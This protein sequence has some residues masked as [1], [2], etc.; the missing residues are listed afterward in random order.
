MMPNDAQP[1]PVTSE[2]AP[3]PARTKLW[4]AEV[5]MLGAFS[6]IGLI[7]FIATFVLIMMRA[8]DSPVQRTLTAEEI[9]R[10]TGPRG[11]RGP[12]GPTGPRGAAG[13]PGL[14]ILRGECAAGNCTVECADSE[15]LLNAYCNPNRTPAAF[16]TEHS[17]LCRATGRGRI[18]VVAACLKDSRR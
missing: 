5:W 8:P 18:E 13:D 15:V 14:R 3:A 16:P 12:A 7:G 11:E 9:Q 17:A 1:S 6:I 4:A 10:L 2:A